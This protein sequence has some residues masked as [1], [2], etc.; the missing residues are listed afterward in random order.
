MK[1]NRSPQLQK[2]RRPATSHNQ[3]L[4]EHTRLSCTTRDPRTA[5]KRITPQAP[6]S[7]P[8][9]ASTM[10]AHQQDR[11]REDRK[12]IEKAI[13]NKLKDI[14]AIKE[15]LYTL[16]Y[17]TTQPHEDTVRDVENLIHELKRLESGLV[18][19]REEAWRNFEQSLNLPALGLPEGSL[20]KAIKGEQPPG[21]ASAGSTQATAE[22]AGVR[23]DDSSELKMMRTRSTKT[24]EDKSPQ[25]KWQ[26]MFRMFQEWRRHTT[27]AEAQ[28]LSEKDAKA[29]K[30]EQVAKLRAAVYTL[31]Q[32]KELTQSDQLLLQ[33]LSQRLRMLHTT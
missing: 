25:E 5:E 13:L 28:R 29:L 30:R 4:S 1:G 18:F 21:A 26:A 22:G 9:Q 20:I 14:H 32:K 15:R 10:E 3:I 11:D 33:Q 12:K 19:L 16:R 31:Q 6:T 8:A 2:R 23:L 24:L 7:Q 27:L 17:D